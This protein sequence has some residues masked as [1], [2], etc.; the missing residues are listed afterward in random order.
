MQTNEE[1]KNVGEKGTQKSQPNTV[2]NRFSSSEHLSPVNPRNW[3]PKEDFVQQNNSISTNELANSLAELAAR[4]GD[5]PVDATVEGGALLDSNADNLLQDWSEK[6]GDVFEDLCYTALAAEAPDEGCEFLKDVLCSV[7]TG[8]LS[9]P[10]RIGTALC[11]D[12]LNKLAVR[13]KHFQHIGDLRTE[14]LRSIYRGNPDDL[15]DLRSLLRSTPYFEIVRSLK[16][17]V[18]TLLKERN[19]FDRAKAG[20]QDRRMMRKNVLMRT[21]KNW[22]M[23]LLNGAFRQWRETAKNTVRQREMLAKYFRRLKKISFKDIFVAWKTLTVN[24][25][26]EKTT[27]IKNEKQQEL[28]ELERALQLAKKQEGDLMMDMVRMETETKHLR[29][30]LEVTHKKIEAQKFDETREIIL[31]VSNSLKAM[32][33]TALQN[34]ETMMLEIERSPDPIK[35]TEMYYIEATEEKFSKEDAHTEHDARLERA[36]RKKKKGNRSRSNTVNSEE[37]TLDES[38]D[39]SMEERNADDAQTVRETLARFEEAMTGFSNLKPDRV[40]LRWLK[41]QLRKCKRGKHPFRRR[42]ENFKDDLRDGICYGLLLNKLS[43]PQNRSKLEKEIDPQRRIDVVMAQAARLEPPASGFITTGHVLGGDSALNAAFVARLYNTHHQLEQGEQ[44]DLRN[45]LHD[46]KTAWSSSLDV[47][48]RIIDLEKWKML[49]VSTSDE[50]L[51]EMLT[52]LDTVVKEIVQFAD[53]LEPRQAEANKTM[54][55]WWKTHHAVNSL[56]WE[57]FTFKATQKEG[58]MNIIDLRKEKQLRLYTKISNFSRFKNTALR[59]CGKNSAVPLDQ[60]LKVEVKIIERY[61]LENFEDLKRIF[62]HYA[63]GADGGHSERMSLNEFW[64]FVKDCSFTRA[65]GADHTALKKDDV[66]DLYLHA[67]EEDDSKRNDVDDIEILPDAFIEALL[68]ISFRKFRKEPTLSKRFSLLVTKY[69]LPKACRTNTESFRTE[70]SQDD[71]QAVFKRNASQ[72]RKIFSY[73]AAQSAK[74]DKKK[75]GSSDEEAGMNLDSWVR[76]LRDTKIITRAGDMRHDFPEEAAKKIFVNVQM[77]GD[78]DNSSNGSGPSEDDTM[79]YLEFLEAM[80]A[81]ACFKLVNPYT[82]LSTR[83]ETFLKDMFLDPALKV[84]KHRKK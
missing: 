5:S 8:N 77:G 71:I 25:K 57:I 52:N 36:D 46:L 59:G 29:G 10:N 64:D 84:I 51:Q 15:S 55:V 81:V 33:N 37:I 38:I 82:P 44:F 48:E 19:R 12:V 72:L 68:D 17:K 4:I 2:S 56:V 32:A 49:R 75:Y 30:R 74:A 35:F 83:L 11:C 79:I 39:K 42:V 73:Y 6:Y 60:D 9:T 34:I 7:S 62:E 13:L 45:R 20:A 65:I 70:I 58:D 67:S 43:Q 69:V 80:G 23:M 47:L 61:L 66:R 40:L 41:W 26:L 31:S 14:L 63:A 16:R 76:V 28:Q 3:R 78:D 27:L 54:Q 24:R 18:D 53:D 22:Q 1:M 50:H 21:S